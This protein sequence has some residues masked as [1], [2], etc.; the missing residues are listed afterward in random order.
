MQSSAKQQQSLGI[1]FSKEI[2]ETRQNVS[3]EVAGQRVS[4]SACSCSMSRRVRSQVQLP[5]VEL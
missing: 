5:F 2:V 4:G 3:E 1:R